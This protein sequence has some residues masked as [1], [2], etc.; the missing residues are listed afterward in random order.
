[1][2]KLIAILIYFEWTEDYI[3]YNCS[4]VIWHFTVLVLSSD[5]TDLEV[6]VH[7]WC[8]CEVPRIILF[9]Y[10]KGAM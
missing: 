5:F 6:H 4:F 2:M 3:V 9:H 10:L 8:G 1:M 7:T